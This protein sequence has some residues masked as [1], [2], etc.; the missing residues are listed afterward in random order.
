[1][2]EDTDVS[3][4]EPALYVNLFTLVSS[5]SLSDQKPQSQ[6]DDD[7]YEIV[8]NVKKG[9]NKPEVKTS[10]MKEIA[11]AVVKTGQSVKKTI[12][13]AR[14]PRDKPNISSKRMQNKEVGAR[15]KTAKKPEKKVEQRK[16][17]EFR[18]NAEETHTLSQQQEHSFARS[19]LST[20]VKDRSKGKIYNTEMDQDKMTVD[21]TL[22]C[23]ITGKA[24][25]SRTD[26][27][28]VVNPPS[29]PNMYVNTGQ[30]AIVS[31]RPNSESKYSVPVLQTPD[32]QNSGSLEST[33]VK[34]PSAE[35]SFSHNLTPEKIAGLSINEVSECLKQLK[36][37]S[38]IDS[39]RENQIDGKLLSMLTGDILKEEFNLKSFQI[40][41]L[42]NFVRD[43]H[44][45]Q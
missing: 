5:N 31:P 25:Y 40:L 35:Q 21:E 27:K 41:K 23:N 30:V 9:H 16:N 2:T 15:P 4:L 22:Y 32:S 39:F 8:E 20:Q 11:A 6:H 3:R 14:V 43:G 37:D 13:T 28:T 29:D 7:V 38:V 1:M 44:I 26:D 17:D 18:P 10:L 36:L 42:Q 24:E 45:P 19:R 33:R 34:I 12:A